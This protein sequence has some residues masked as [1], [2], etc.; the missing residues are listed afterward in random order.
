MSWFLFF[1][2][3]GVLYCYSSFSAEVTTPSAQGWVSG[4]NTSVSPARLLDF[5]RTF[6][7]V[8]P[9]LDFL[10]PSARGILLVCLLSDPV[11]PGCS[12]SESLL[13]AF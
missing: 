3:P 4:E 12:L 1:R 11:K 9:V 10:A 13:F 7:L 8:M 5:L 2:F 6:S